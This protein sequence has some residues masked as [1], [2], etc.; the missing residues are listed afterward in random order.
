MYML[1]CRKVLTVV[2]VCS[3]W[4][5]FSYLVFYKL[6]YINLPLGFVENFI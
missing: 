6:L 4:V 1:S 3:G 5:L 2:L